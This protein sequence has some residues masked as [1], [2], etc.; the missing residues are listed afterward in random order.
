MTGVAAQ[1]SEVNMADPRPF[2]AS[3]DIVMK[4]FAVL[5]GVAI[6]DFLRR[7]F[8]TRQAISNDPIVAFC[9]F[10]ALTLLSLR[11]FLGSANH[12]KSKYVTSGSLR[13]KNIFFFKDVSF[14]VLFGGLAVAISQSS[15]VHA[16]NDRT[17]FLLLAAATWG[18]VDYVFTIAL[19][20]SWPGRAF[21]VAWLVINVLQFFA[22]MVFD[23]LFAASE[24][25]VAVSLVVLYLVFLGVDHSETLKSCATPPTEE[26]VD[27]I[28]KCYAILS[29]VCIGVV[30]AALLILPGLSLIYRVGAVIIGTLVPLGCS[31]LYCCARAKSAIGDGT[32]S[33]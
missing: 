23:H 4:T 20:G 26:T 19:T 15:E 9:F 27:C 22:T 11:Y 10:A 31:A 8:D 25:L 30:L 32:P 6:A 28:V 33:A 18:L 29:L 3:V 13:H 21:W 7:Q 24:R 2:E 17:S 12:L 1:T 16:F 14:L 5:V